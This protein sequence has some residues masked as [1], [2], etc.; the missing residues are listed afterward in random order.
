MDEFGFCG[1]R[2]TLLKSQGTSSSG[3][4]TTSPRHHEK[5]NEPPALAISSMFPSRSTNSTF[6]RSWLCVLQSWWI[7]WQSGPNVPEATTRAK[8]TVHFHT[9]PHHTSSHF[10][11]SFAAAEPP[12]WGHLQASSRNQQNLLGLLTI[13]GSCDCPP[14]AGQCRRSCSC[15]SMPEKSPVAFPKNKTE[16][17]LNK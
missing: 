6:Q 1:S 4:W 17:G 15:L 11:P 16:L 3:A 10:S 12:E 9:C 13:N 8:V 14:C 7:L 5:H 2:S